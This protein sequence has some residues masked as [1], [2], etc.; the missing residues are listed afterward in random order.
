MTVAN[1]SFFRRL[2]L[3]WRTLLDA[4]FAADASS[5]DKSGPAVSQAP[6]SAP[7]YLKESS[8]EAALQ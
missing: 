5:L 3:A 7:S 1:P 2:A 8:P 6:E 4:T